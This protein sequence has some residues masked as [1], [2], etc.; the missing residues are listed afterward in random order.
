MV[1]PATINIVPFLAST[2]TDALHQCQAPTDAL[3]LAELVCRCNPG[4]QVDGRIEVSLGQTPHQLEADGSL[5]GWPQL[6][7]GGTA[8][9]T[10]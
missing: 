2:S 3:Q 10:G 5:H 4:H 8:K 9:V 6:P 1:S 7:R